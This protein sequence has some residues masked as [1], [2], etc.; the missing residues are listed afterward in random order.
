MDASLQMVGGGMATIEAFP[1]QESGSL[2]K[3]EACYV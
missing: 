3:L 2:V 1:H